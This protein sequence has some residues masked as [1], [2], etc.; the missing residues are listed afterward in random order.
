MMM[1]FSRCLPSFWQCRVGLAVVGMTVHAGIHGPAALVEPHNNTPCMTP[2]HMADMH[3]H[4][5]R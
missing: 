4:T 1:L 2:T 5:C 3:I